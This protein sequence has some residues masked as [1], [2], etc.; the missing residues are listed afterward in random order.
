MMFGLL[1]ETSMS[2]MRPPMLA[3][4]MLRNRNER[5]S[6]SVDWLIIGAAAAWPPA[7]APTSEVAT[8]MAST[9]RTCHD[10]R[11]TRID[12]RGSGWVGRTG[13][14][15][16]WALASG[17]VHTHRPNIPFGPAAVKLVPFQL[18][19]PKGSESPAGWEP[20]GR[21]SWNGT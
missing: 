7:C 14:Y 20:L 10:K 18:A 16:L 2:S 9:D 5:R 3:G 4:P 8:G 11:G 6:G 13:T 17:L 21:I 15:D 1:S 12:M 19:P